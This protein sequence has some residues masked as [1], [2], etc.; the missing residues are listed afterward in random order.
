VELGFLHQVR[1]VFIA[2]VRGMWKTNI[3][4]SLFTRGGNAGASASFFFFF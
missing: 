3:I 2:V 1:I 4:S